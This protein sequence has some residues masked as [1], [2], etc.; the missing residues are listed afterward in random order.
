MVLDLNGHQYHGYL[1]WMY[2]IT[3]PIGSQNPYKTNSY[4]TLIN[5]FDIYIWIFTIV[6]S[7]CV[8]TS[9]ILMQLLWSRATEEV[10]PNGWL[11]QGKSFKQS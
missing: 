9:L 3:F 11:F 2:V 5:P 8:F 4:D 1:P 7:I 10:P 6:A